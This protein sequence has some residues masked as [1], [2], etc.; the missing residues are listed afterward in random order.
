MSL[1]ASIACSCTVMSDRTG[2][3]AD[4]QTGL[5]SVCLFLYVCVC[6]YDIKEGVRGM[7]AFESLY[8]MIDVWT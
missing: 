5:L 8:K 3:F 2:L 7:C 6:F 4:E 1:F